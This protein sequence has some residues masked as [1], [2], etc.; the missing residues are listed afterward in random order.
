MEPPFTP[1][2]RVDICD[3]TEWIFQGIQFADGAELP[4][5]DGSPESGRVPAELI[6]KWQP[7]VLECLDLLDSDGAFAHFPR[8]GSR[9]T[10]PAYDMEVLRIVRGRWVELKNEDNKR[11]FSNGKS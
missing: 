6:A 2:E 4:S 10:Q 1:G 7:W 3:V 11:G 9:R 5:V 8:P